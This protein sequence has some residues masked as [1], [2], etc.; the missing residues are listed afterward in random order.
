MLCKGFNR[1]RKVQR[2][3]WRLLR[4]LSLIGFTSKLGEEVEKLNDISLAARPQ[5]AA[6]ITSRDR[7][8]VKGEK[9]TQ[10]GVST[11][12]IQQ[13]LFQTLQQLEIQNKL[14][15]EN[16]AQ[17]RRLFTEFLRR[18]GRKKVSSGNL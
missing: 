8:V 14:T 12:S 18:R 16:V 17:N 4:I 13:F 15:V 2:L 5:L 6:A 7:L 3:Q 10:G 1:K 9:V 11:Y